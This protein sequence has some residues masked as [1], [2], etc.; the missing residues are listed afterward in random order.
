M[1]RS[2]VPGELVKE[3]GVP[4]NESLLAK[5]VGGLSIYWCLSAALPLSPAPKACT[6]SPPPPSARLD[7]WV[8]SALLH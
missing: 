6:L 2:G 5:T 7:S 3:S 8:S 1:V 4:S